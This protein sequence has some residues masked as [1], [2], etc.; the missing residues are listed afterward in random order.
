MNNCQLLVSLFNFNVVAVHLVGLLKYDCVTDF[1]AF[2]AVYVLCKQGNDSQKAVN[3]LR[4]QFCRNTK[5]L[6]SSDDTAA[7]QTDSQQ[8]IPVDSKPCDVVFKD[9]AGGLYAWAKCVDKDFP[10]Y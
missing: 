5:E 8:G 7:L 1:D 10:V 6:L 2:F 4:E 3:I 9:I